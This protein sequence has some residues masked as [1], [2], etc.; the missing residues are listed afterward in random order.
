M[1]GAYKEL[2]LNIIRDIKLLGE[3]SYRIHLLFLQRYFLK[4]KNESTWGPIPG[5]LWNLLL[6]MFIS[7]GGGGGGWETGVKKVGQ[8]YV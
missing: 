4:H 1:G 8:S 2:F 5:H 7:L 6:F 3:V